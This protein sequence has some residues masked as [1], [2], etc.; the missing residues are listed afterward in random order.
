MRLILYPDEPVK[1]KRAFNLMDIAVSGD[2]S[3]M[4]R[5]TIIDS[6]ISGNPPTVYVTQ[7]EL[8]DEGYQIGN[9]ITVR[10][11]VEQ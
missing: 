8:Q 4:Q 9:H 3:Q 1:K 11:E 5:D 7:K 2:V 10:I 6:I